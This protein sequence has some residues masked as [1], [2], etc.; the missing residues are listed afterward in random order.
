[1]AQDFRGNALVRNAIQTATQG[2]ENWSGPADML[3][4]IEAGAYD[5]VMPDVMKIGGVTRWMQAAT[6]AETHALRM[7]NHLFVE[8]SAQ[9]LCVTPT[10]HWLEY[11]DWFDPIIET[12]LRVENGFAL[13]LDIPG[14]G[15]SWNEEAVAEFRVD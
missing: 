2:G 8:F 12:P 11:V 15:V 14:S 1:M 7:S 13:P 4:A 5:H 10:A 3:K 6:L 9:L